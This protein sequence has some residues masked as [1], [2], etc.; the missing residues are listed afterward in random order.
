MFLPLFVLKV[1]IFFHSITY[2]SYFLFGVYD[3]VVFIS[4]LLSPAQF[5]KF[6]GALALDLSAVLDIYVF[7]FLR[8]V[9]EVRCGGSP[10][11]SAYC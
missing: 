7:Y 5:L 4:V 1:A 3:V 9:A 8:R 2:I 11:Y 6:G 10:L